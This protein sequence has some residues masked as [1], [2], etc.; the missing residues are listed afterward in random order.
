MTKRIE[1]D[2]GQGAAAD[3]LTVLHTLARKDQPEVLATKRFLA[4]TNGVAYCTE[5]DRPYLFRVEE[6]SVCS[7]R[8]LFDT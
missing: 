6:V 3:T 5:Y 7:L 4:A 1:G 2:T 8:D